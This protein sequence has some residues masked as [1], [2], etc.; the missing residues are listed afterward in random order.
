[1]DVNWGSMAKVL[2]M[3]L[4]VTVAVVSVFA[5]GIL[6]GSARL[7]A[8]ERGESGAVGLTGAVLCL[9]ACAAMVLYGIYLIVP[10]FH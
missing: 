10:Q 8:Q 4:G 3:S 1:M 7:A 9:T 6:A 2:V 5:I